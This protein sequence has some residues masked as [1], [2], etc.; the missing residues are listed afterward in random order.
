MVQWLGLGK[1]DGKSCLRVQRADGMPSSVR[2]L[3]FAEKIA[4]VRHLQIYI[5]RVWVD[6]IALPGQLLEYPE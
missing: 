4:V 6:R 3:V 1:D 2:T 5:W